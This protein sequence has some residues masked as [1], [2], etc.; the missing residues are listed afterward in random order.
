MRYQDAK[1]DSMLQCR[2]LKPPVTFAEP[3]M[4]EVFTNS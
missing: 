4:V 3:G 2:E 1:K